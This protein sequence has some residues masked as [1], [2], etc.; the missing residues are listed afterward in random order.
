MDAMGT[1]PVAG[2]RFI[3]ITAAR[4]QL[5]ALY[6]LAEVPA[7]FVPAVVLAVTMESPL[8]SLRIRPHWPVSGLQANY[9]PWLRVS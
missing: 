8:P 5:A 7:G 2:A 6:A 1:L 4:L 3:A 9:S